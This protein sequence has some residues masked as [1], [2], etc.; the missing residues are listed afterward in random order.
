MLE[1]RP[2]LAPADDEA[3]RRPRA[4]TDLLA[5]RGVRYVSFEDWQRL[6]ALEV[7]R[8]EE[9]GRPRVKLCRV[10]DMLAALEEATAEV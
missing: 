4:V 10:D 2:A 5:A 6:D 3:A 7:A 8:G 9:Q 1:D